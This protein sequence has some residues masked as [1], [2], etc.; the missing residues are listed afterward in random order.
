MET[1][2]ELLAGLQDKLDGIDTQLADLYVKYGEVASELAQAKLD[3]L[4]NAAAIEDLEGVVAANKA[5]LENKIGQLSSQL[6][7]A[8]ETLNQTINTVKEQLQQSIDGV[9]TNLDNAVTDLQGKIDTINETLATINETLGDHGSRISALEGTVEQQGQAIAALKADL[10]QAQR[11][12]VKI[13]G[14]LSTLNAINAKRLTSVTLIPSAYVGGIPT[15]D[16]LSASFVPMV[17]GANGEYTAA[18]DGAAAKIVTNE[19]TYAF[20]RLNPSGVELTDIKADDVNFVQM[21]AS[22]RAGNDPA[23]VKVAKVEKEQNG[24]LKVYAT[25]ADNFTSDFNFSG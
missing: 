16:F 6:T 1:Y 5:E 11:D 14:A 9:Q 19:E 10:Q 25:K 20:Y 13:N 12:I 8:V 17:A 24:V 22:S 21:I 3:I 4:E 7:S 23:V 15:I 18:P 2:S